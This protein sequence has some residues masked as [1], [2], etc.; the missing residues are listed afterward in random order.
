MSVPLG[1][2]AY[3]SETSL[4]KGISFHFFMQYVKIGC[5][6]STSLK[7]TFTIGWVTMQLTLNIVAQTL[8]PIAQR[9][10]LSA[11]VI[12]ETAS[13]TQH[14]APSISLIIPTSVLT[15]QS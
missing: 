10:W 8:V 3:S 2:A 14:S 6:P 12:V 11:G 7:G 4:K 5:L 13:K 1:F 9:Y 15:S